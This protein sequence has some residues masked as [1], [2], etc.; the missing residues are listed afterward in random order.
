MMF[1]FL[2]TRSMKSLEKR[3]R[4]ADIKDL[5]NRANGFSLNLNARNAILE[6]RLQPATMRELPGLSLL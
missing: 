3:V 1:W 5:N 6:S 4:I 2:A